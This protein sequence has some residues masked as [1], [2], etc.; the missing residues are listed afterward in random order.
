MTIPDPTARRLRAH[1]VL[2]GER[3][4]IRLRGEM[5]LGTAPHLR[6]AIC[7]CLG[8]HHPCALD[9]HLAEVTFCDCTGLNT[10]LWARQEAA[11]AG[12][13]LVVR[14]P[15]QHGVARLL[16][17]TGAEAVLGPPLAA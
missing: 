4:A 17:V 11:D 9:L 5:D 6:R 12:A 7:A 14:G 15:L 1:V 8:Q 16:S 2:H 3:A 13:A 10:L